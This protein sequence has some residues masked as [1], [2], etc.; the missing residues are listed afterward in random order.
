M[1]NTC[2]PKSLQ[3][4]S[5]STGEAKR[6]RASAEGSEVDLKVIENVSVSVLFNGRERNERS[7]LICRI[8]WN[9][10]THSAATSFIMRLRFCTRASYFLTRQTRVTF[11]CRSWAGRGVESWGMKAWGFPLRTAQ[12]PLLLVLL[13]IR[14]RIMIRK[15]YFGTSRNIVFAS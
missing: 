6:R 4:V 12:K 5:C 11:S 13:R 9:F 14:N 3:V 1:R 8:T 7:R 10:Q 15:V 2:Q